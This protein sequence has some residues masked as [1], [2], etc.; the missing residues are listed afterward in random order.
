[1]TRVVGYSRPLGDDDDE[2]DAA[3]LRAA[4]ADEVQFDH[5]ALDGTALASCL[6][7]LNPGDELLVSRAARLASTQGTILKT[8]ASLA[9]RRVA[10]RSLAEPTL[11]TGASV[12]PEQVLVALNEL[13][14]E[15]IGIRIRAGMAAAIAEGKRPGRPSV[16]TPDRIEMALELRSLGRSISHIARVLGVSAGAVQRA[17]PRTIA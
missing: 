6:Q 11:S 5:G 17:L 3:I 16:M 2:T 7:S 15:L 8:L 4:G 13:R 9:R 12:S 1:V 10:F 14:R